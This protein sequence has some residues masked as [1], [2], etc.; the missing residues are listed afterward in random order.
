MSVLSKIRSR[1]GLLV[2]VIGVALFAFILG[3]IFTSGRSIFSAKETNIGVIA[4]EEV[5]IYD[6]ERKVQEQ[7]DQ[8]KKSNPNTPP[9]EAK[10]DQVV[11]N[12]WQQTI[13]DKVFSKEYARLGLS[14]STDELA[15][16][17]F[18]KD[19]N[20]VM[21]QYFSDQ[22]TGQ[23]I[24]KY[25]RPDGKLNMP[26][27]R[28]YASE[29]KEDEEK[30]WVLLEKYIRD[31]RRQ[32]K[33]M[34]LIKKGLYVTTAQAKRDSADAGTAYSVR[35]I[36]KKYSSM[37]DS[38]LKVTDSDLLTWYNA[39]QYK[40]KIKE[41]SRSVD[42]VSFDIA[43]SQKDVADMKNEMK[44]R[45]EDFKSKTGKE[46]TAFVLGESDSRTYNARYV[47]KG[48]LNPSIDSI[49]SKG[50]TGTV[51]GP[52]EEN[53]KIVLY[54]V[55]GKKTSSDSAKVRHLL[56][57]YKGG[58]RA[59]S[60]VRR[61]KEQAKMLADSL[62]KLVKTKKRKLED[63]VAKYTDDP[64]SKDAPDGKAGNKGDYGWFTEESGFVPAFKNAGLQGKKGDVTV[65]ETE[66]GY[67]LI[68]VLDKT[69]ETPKVQIVSIERQE[70]P[71]KAT[72][73]SIYLKANTFAGKNT[74]L[75]L[76][77]KA[78]VKDG[79]NKGIAAD[80]HPTDRTIRGLD[81]PKELVR[82]MFA[83][84]RKKGD[85]SQPF[86]LGEKFVIACLTSVKE[87]GIAPLEEVKD[88]VEV[89]VKKQKKADK[90]IEM[91]AKASAGV[92]KIDE[93]A[94]KLRE[95]AL[96][97]DNLTFVNSFIPGIG[98]E[99]ELIG[100]MA[101]DKAGV[102]SKPV[103]GNG[104]VFVMMIEKASKANAAGDVKMIRKQSLS[105][106]QSRADGEVFEALKENAN[107][108]DN[109]AKFY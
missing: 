28:K 16:Q 78:V 76:Y 10:T 88:K 20:P 109:R 22:Q 1:A 81:A 24:K 102:I 107:I 44:A 4:G 49:V 29:M 27:V 25:A 90:F 57:A 31:S 69:K 40:F 26:A 67:H 54:K 68:E 42:Y 14:V 72:I 77:E 3:D 9:D 79:L 21:N 46:D 23:V 2:A 58:A 33:Y 6:F 36:A 38:T 103:Q 17:M 30:N 39:H 11:Q 99:N 5:S 95:P 96:T 98:Q 35:Y 62:L 74:T 97:A 73:D 53:K 106:M 89:E 82:W 15:D 101:G 65:V 50:I 105:A 12:L 92:T 59:D 48:S 94:T 41:A 83:E 55:L 13:S 19:P 43:P 108:K 93:L 64:G 37:S 84:E 104:G 7:I 87:K 100:V 66:F 70:Q 75:D 18:G 60:T 32:S 85:V 91:F 56:L 86:Q 61:T 8:M 71:S 47:K 80:V 34:N 45:V 51:I 63:L 52:V